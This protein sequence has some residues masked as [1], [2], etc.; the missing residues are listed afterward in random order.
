[1]LADAGSRRM[2]VATLAIAYGVSPAAASVVADY[3]EAALGGGEA[4]VGD[5]AGL[6]G[7]STRTVWR[8]LQGV[9]CRE[10]IGRGNESMFAWA[11]VVARMGRPPAPSMVQAV[12]KQGHDPTLDG[13]PGDPEPLKSEKADPT[14]VGTPVDFSPVGAEG[15]VSQSARGGAGLTIPGC[16]SVEVDNGVAEAVP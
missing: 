15:N 6:Y 11:D 8:R 12:D 3:A 14:P 2:L 4:S 5:I 10:G 16:D 13:V 7:V 9:P 1:M